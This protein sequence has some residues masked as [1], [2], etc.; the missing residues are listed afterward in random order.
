MGFKMLHLQLGL[1]YAERERALA[2][3]VEFSLAGHQFGSA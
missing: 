3:G 1:G 2:Y